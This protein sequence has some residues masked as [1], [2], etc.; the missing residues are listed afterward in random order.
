MYIEFK[1]IRFK[2]ILSYG[3]QMTELDFNNGINIV[4]AANGSGKSTILDAL[5]F[6]LFGKPYRDIKLNNLINEINEKDLYT[7]V[8]FNLGKDSYT[9]AR[10]LKPTLLEITKNG[11]QLDL[12]SSKKLNQD[13]IDKLLGI[14]IRLFKNIVRKRDLYPWRMPSRAAFPVMRL[15]FSPTFG[16]MP[17]A[18]APMSRGSF[19]LMNGSKNPMEFE[20][21]PTQATIAPIFMPRSAH[22][23]FTSRPMT[24]WNSRTMSGN[25]A[26]PSALPRT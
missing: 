9:I 21:P 13:E 11:Q 26:G 5:T 16:P 15:A 19:S 23:L 6:C 24:L 4:T 22:C 12:L 3:N 25:G 7:E 8:T 20:P 10:G 14:N 1:K 2:N 17:P 18:S